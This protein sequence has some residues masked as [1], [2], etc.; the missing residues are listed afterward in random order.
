MVIYY[1]SKITELT[2]TWILLIETFDSD[3][4]ETANGK[5]KV[6]DNLTVLYNPI[7]KNASEALNIQY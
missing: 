6:M 5:N 1:L 3:A 4:C 2:I 7:V